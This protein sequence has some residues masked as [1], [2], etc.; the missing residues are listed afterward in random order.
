M[1]SKQKKEVE[2]STTIQWKYIWFYVMNEF[3][4]FAK[5]EL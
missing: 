5:S 4:Q 3:N 2:L 1:K